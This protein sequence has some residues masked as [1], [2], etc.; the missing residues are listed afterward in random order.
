MP[1]HKVELP[2]VLQSRSQGADSIIPDRDKQQQQRS[3]QPRRTRPSALLPGI[4][5]VSLMLSS[6]DCTFLTGWLSMGSA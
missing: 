6:S 4:R 1:G 3:L 5:S 2:N